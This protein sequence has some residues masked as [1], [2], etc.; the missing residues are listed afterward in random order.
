MILTQADEFRRLMSKERNR[1][2][3]EA[4]RQKFV[5]GAVATRAG[6]QHPVGVPLADAVFDMVS[7]FV[8]YCFYRSHAAAFART[9]YQSA[10]LKAHHPALYMACVLEHLPKF[11]PLHTTVEEAKAFGVPV[12]PPD[13]LFSGFKYSLERLQNGEAAIRVPLHQIK[14][15]SPD[16]AARIVLEHAL[17][18]F[19]SLDDLFRRVRSYCLNRFRSLFVDMSEL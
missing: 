6:S 10:Y 12:L 1:D 14:E 7:N 16:S 3:M 11:F 5:S 18:P 4:M 17:G 19:E 2:E 9:V 8:G 15:F 13:I